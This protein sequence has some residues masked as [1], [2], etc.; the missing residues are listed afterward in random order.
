MKISLLIIATNQYTCFLER[1]LDSADKFFCKEQEVVFNIFTDKMD[2]AS[3]LLMNKP[4]KDRLNFMK[5]E[6]K[7]FPYTTLYRFHFFKQHKNYINDCGYYFYVDVDCEFKQPIM[8]YEVIGARVA[9]QHC[10]FVNERGPYEID[11]DSTSCVNDDEG[12]TYY[13]GGFWGFANSEFWKMIDAT[14]KMI[15]D[16]ASKNIIPVWHDESV[17]NRYLITHKPDRILTPSFHYPENSRHIQNKWLKQGVEYE[18]KLLLLQKN[19]NEI[20]Q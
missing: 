12:I 20:R 5:V 2:V 4:Y 8:A 17:I 16:D 7:P 15:D 11:K 18:C 6:H 19:H 3:K 10:G 14:T 1:L 13:G 9:V